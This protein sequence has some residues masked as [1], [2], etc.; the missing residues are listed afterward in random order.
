[1]RFPLYCLLLAGSILTAA[2]TGE[3]EAARKA[4][5]ERPRRV[6]Y[7]NDGDD[8]TWYPKNLPVTPENF[9]SRRL[10]TMEGSRVDGM[11]YVVQISF[12]TTTF[13]SKVGRM[14]QRNTQTPAAFAANPELVRQG[15]DP[16]RL[17]VDY[18]HANGKEIFASFR[19]ND[20]HDSWW[21]PGEKN[22]WVWLFP[23]FKREHPELLFG[24]Q[25]KR[26]PFGAWSAVDYE[27]PIVR[28]KLLRLVEEVCDKYEEDGL[29]FDFFRWPHIF[30]SVGWGKEA[31]QEQRDLFTGLFR[32]I[33]AAAEKA[34]RKRGKPILIALRVPDSVGYCRGIGLDLERWMELKLFDIMVAGG[35]MRLNP[36]E[37]SVEL[38]RKYGIQ[39]L[40]SLDM[41]RFDEPPGLLIRDIPEAWHA[42]QAAALTAGVDGLYYFNVFTPER[43]K[44]LMLGSEADVKYLDKRYFLTDIVIDTPNK[45]LLNGERFNR[46]PRLSSLDPV[47]LQPG[48][49]RRFP[50]TFGDDLEALRREGHS[51]EVSAVLYGDIPE[52][53][54]LTVT[55]NGRKLTQTA[56]GRKCLLFSIPEGALRKGA[57]EVAFSA[58]VKNAARPKQRLIADGSYLLKGA[59]QAPWRRLWTAHNFAES[60]EIVENAYRLTDS[61]SGEGDIANL[62]YPVYG[63]NDTV[64]AKF[65]AKLLSA[66]DDRS[67]VLR[68]ADN[69]H[70]EIV[71]LMPGKVAL[72]NGKVSA[73]F[74]TTGRFHRY[75]LRMTADK[76]TLSADGR[77]LLKAPA[78]VRVNTPEGDLS[79]YS[80]YLDKMNDS[81]LLF[82]SL[83]GPGTGTAL[84]RNISITEPS[85][86][87]ELQEFVIDVRFPESAE[88]APAVSG[89]DRENRAENAVLLPFKP[90]AGLAPR[91]I[92]R[93][94]LD[95]R[96]GDHLLAIGDG[97][98][99]GAIRIT[100]DG[101]FS[102][103]GPKRQT[104]AVAAAQQDEYLLELDEGAFR[105][106]RNNRLVLDN[107]AP[108]AIGRTAE[109]PLSAEAV[110]Q[111]KQGGLAAKGP[112]AID[113][114]LKVE[115]PDQTPVRQLAE[116]LSALPAA[117][118]FRAAE[119]MPRAPWKSTYGSDFARLEER[120]GE[121]ILLLDNDNPQNKFQIFRA[122]VPASAGD[123]CGAKFRARVVRSEPGKSA[124]NFALIPPGIKGG[125][126]PLVIKL[127]ESSFTIDG[128]GEFPLSAG[129]A[130]D[131]ALAL[132][133]TN[134]L[135]VVLVDGEIAAAGIL[136]A[137][138]AGK[139]A[140]WFG[141]GASATTGAAE[142]ESL[143]VYLDQNG[144]EGSAK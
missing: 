52:S 74:D 107:I 68:L 121:K 36:W 37:S 12:T 55:V 18:C 3:W 95:A 59:R 132:D 135:A 56:R 106:Y 113:A 45:Y 39:L 116:K 112:G 100:P 4:A 97:R 11:F 69:R 89:W 130:H 142:L 9:L 60:E 134:G 102:L 129:K 85:G 109:L 99:F 72:L 83:S 91:M 54:E 42:R 124:F 137:D 63:G 75:E 105:V 120:G 84:W 71:S 108:A 58:K 143:T 22:R 64:T 10:R 51:P 81:S 139:A 73:P 144:K 23:E 38:C 78:R 27:S 14:L 77:E 136:S 29:E 70:V 123:I 28:E 20:I 46:L 111:L 49:P 86:A 128:W 62:L 67:A 8:A 119:G 44:N 25:Q 127:F 96:N 114:A 104:L 1:M 48:R 80:Y 15:T 6:I 87:A 30:K 40:A 141:D 17:A 131:F 138:P 32:D 57:N 34:G 115:F 133:R 93:V 21:A 2:E 43:V 7:N 35:N 140:A 50:L 16:F 66:T 65:E 53:T 31:T 94:K 61:G 126:I 103:T 82:G 101:V 98:R 90:A 41:P 26:P 19:M 122:P 92:G 117:F 79:G 118:G 76:V 5:L 47:R 88:K 110:K 13:D 24:S 33:R 125:P